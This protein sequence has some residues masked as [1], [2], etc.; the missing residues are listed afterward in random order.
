MLRLDGYPGDTASTLA[1]LK[2]LGNRRWAKDR[3]I[4]GTPL[5]EHPEFLKLKCFCDVSMKCIGL[6]LRLYFVHDI[7]V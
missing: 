4:F 7:L 6:N 3:G 5:R 1:S 2:S